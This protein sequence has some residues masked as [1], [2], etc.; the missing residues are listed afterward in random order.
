MLAEQRAWEQAQEAE[1][2]RWSTHDED[3]MHVRSDP[4]LEEYLRRDE[5]ELQARADEAM[6]AKATNHIS[7]ESGSENDDD[8]DMLIL[9]ALEEFERSQQNG[10]RDMDLS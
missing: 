5:E 3:E 10:Q 1:A 7:G 6:Q 4:E 2:A 9:E 8:F